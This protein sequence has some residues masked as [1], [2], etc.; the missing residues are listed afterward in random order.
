MRRSRVVRDS[1]EFQTFQTFATVAESQRWRS[2]DAH[3]SRPLLAAGLL[4]FSLPS[5]TQRDNAV[6]SMSLS[7]RAASQCVRAQWLS[8]T[9]LPY[10]SLYWRHASRHQRQLLP[11]N[12]LTSTATQ[13]PRS[14]TFSTAT[15]NPSTESPAASPSPSA[16]AQSLSQPPRPAASPALPS[17]DQ[18]RYRSAVL[19]RAGATLR[20]HHLPRH[21]LRT[22]HNC[23]AL[24]SHCA[25]CGWSCPVYG[26]RRA[27][28]G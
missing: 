4:P 9:S 13:T 24:C 16:S 17:P 18:L 3:G 23:S 25:P 19:R 12:H 26:S 8:C 22:R 20:P 14:A 11:H 2:T 5:S 28:Y 10:P 1:I 7:R 6:T 27:M 21:H 15:P